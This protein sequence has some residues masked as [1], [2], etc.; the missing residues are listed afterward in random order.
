LDLT[1]IPKKLNSHVFTVMTAAAKY[2]APPKG[3]RLDDKCPMLGQAIVRLAYARTASHGCAAFTGTFNVAKVKVLKGVTFTGTLMGKKFAGSFQTNFKK[4]SLCRGAAVFKGSRHPVKFVYSDEDGRAVWGAPLYQTWVK[5]CKDG[6]H[7]NLGKCKANICKCSHGTAASGTACKINRK[8]LC[9]AC[10]SS[11]TL[12]GSKCTPGKGKKGKSSKSALPAALQAEKFGCKSILSKKK[13]VAAKDGRK[14]KYYSFSACQWCCGKHCTKSGGSLCAPQV[15]LLKQKDYTG[16]SMNGLGYNSCPKSTKKAKTKKATKK[17]GNA[18]KKLPE[19][20]L[21]KKKTAA[22]LALLSEAMYSVGRGVASQ[23]AHRK[24]VQ[25]KAA[26]AA[27]RSAVHM[28]FSEPRPVKPRAEVPL[29][30]ELADMSES[31]LNHLS[32]TLDGIIGD[33]VK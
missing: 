11:Y 26:S 6:F 24:V 31:E 25:M 27:T 30:E 17:K 32:G 3:D 10:D 15:W 5:S 23:Q 7:Y 29:S 8:K 2:P 33:L 13:C 28:F 9:A 18:K 4:K 12:K 16:T 19:A 14:G 20:L 1:S 22:P 21:K